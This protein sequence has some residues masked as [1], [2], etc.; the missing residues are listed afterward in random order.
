M[1]RSP[2]VRCDSGVTG[3]KRFCG[4]TRVST[5][6]IK[7]KRSPAS[8]RPISA[9]CMKSKAR[10][11]ALSI[12]DRLRPSITPDLI[13]TA[14]QVRLVRDSL[15][16]FREDA[17]PFA[18]LFYGKLFELDPGSRRLFHN[19]LAL[20]GR[21]LMDMLGSV[22][23]SLDTFQPMQARLAELGRQHAQYGV[24]SEQ[25]DTLTTALLWSIGQALVSGFDVPTWETWR[26]AIHAISVARKADAE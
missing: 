21:K 17:E 20:Q 9:R 11:P 22:V 8:E 23:E 5:V 13:M 25:Y 19:D 24:S 26:L 15:D 1:P 18:L 10:S 3:S 2:A 4:C 6:G 14:D 12:G 7:Y 16:A